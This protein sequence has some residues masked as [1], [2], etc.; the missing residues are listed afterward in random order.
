MAFSAIP[1]VSDLCGVDVQWFQD[2]SSQDFAKFQGIVSVNDF[3]FPRR[4]Q[5]LH[6][7]LRGLLGSFC[8]TR[9][10]LYPLRCQVLA[11]P[12]HIDDCS[13]I[14][15]LHW[16]F[17]DP[18]WSS[19]QNVPFWARLYQHVFCKKPSLFS[20][21]SRYR[22]LGPSES[23]CRHYVHPNPVPLLLAAPLEVHEMTLEV[24]WLPC[25]G[26][27]QGSV[28]VLSSTKHS[29]NSC[30]QS[31][32]SWDLSLCT[33][34]DSPYFYFVFGFCGF[35]QGVSPEAFHSYFH[36]YLVL[37]FR[38]ICWHQIRNPVTKMMEK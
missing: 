3:W 9:V 13:E 28:E 37:D 4:F 15:L 19:H 7:V 22:N 18:L 2:N 24:S 29:L 16:E 20:S 26:F 31:G 8:F 35:T 23:A 27:P 6:L 33:S 5:E 14:I 38:C 34:S 11:P 25:S 36:F 1:C 12:R 30:S 21:S 17:C 10:W 32:N